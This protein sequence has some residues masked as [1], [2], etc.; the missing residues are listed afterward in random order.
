[1]AN[2]ISTNRSD[3]RSSREDQRTIPI[4]SR[5]HDMSNHGIVTGLMTLAGRASSVIFP[6]IAAWMILALAPRVGSGQTPPNC[7][8]AQELAGCDN[9]NLN[10]V[11][12]DGSCTAAQC[13]DCR[14]IGIR[15]SDGC[16]FSQIT[17]SSTECFSPCAILRTPSGDHIWTTQ[18]DGPPPANSTSCDLNGKLLYDATGDFPV[19]GGTCT[20]CNTC[21]SLRRVSHEHYHYSFGL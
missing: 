3:A 9:C 4:T 2:K 14:Y 20:D 5:I 8:C 1:M 13:T 17:L 15:P 10:C 12:T 6:M 11:A 7:F 18:N 21:A 19:C 16:C